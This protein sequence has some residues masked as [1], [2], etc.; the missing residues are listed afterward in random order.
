MGFHICPLALVPRYAFPG[1]LMSA[2]IV[3]TTTATEREADGLARSLVD[4]RLA[5][6]VHIQAVRSI[7]RWKGDVL[8]EPEWR[9]AIKSTAEQYVAIETHILE[10]H[11]YQT[12]EIVC[13]QI[14]RGS[15]DYLRWLDEGIGT[16]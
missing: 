11:S 8:E 7:Y 4:A 2:I 10:R 5:A 6:C 3:L 14:E 1:F 15:A 9:L 12:P 13:L 16:I